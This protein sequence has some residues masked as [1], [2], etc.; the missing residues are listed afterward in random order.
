MMELTG[1]IRKNF[2]DFHL[3]IIV[4]RSD[5]SGSQM[6]S[7]QELSNGELSHSYLCHILAVPFIHYMML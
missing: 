4:C 3:S 2:M 7:V 6:Y 1:S 5:T